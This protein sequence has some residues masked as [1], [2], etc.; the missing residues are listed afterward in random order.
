MVACRQ[1]RPDGKGPVVRGACPLDGPAAAR[2]RVGREVHQDGGDGPDAI[3]Q[4]RRSAGAMIGAAQA[5]SAMP[6]QRRSLAESFIASTT[7]AIS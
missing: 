7:R 5:I 3:A 6:T 1:A 4:V 2:H